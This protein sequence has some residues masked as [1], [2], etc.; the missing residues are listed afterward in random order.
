MD[1][2]DLQ[3]SLGNIFTEF[4]T[5]SNEFDLIGTHIYRVE[6]TSRSVVCIAL[7]HGF[8]ITL[9]CHLF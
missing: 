5:P 7:K 2:V 6:V 1:L 9:T 3:N 8:D 4:M